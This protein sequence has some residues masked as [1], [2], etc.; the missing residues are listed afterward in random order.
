VLL[1]VRFT[2]NGVCSKTHN[3]I[4]VARTNEDLSPY[5][6]N[7]CEFLRTNYRMPTRWLTGPLQQSLSPPWLKP[8]VTPLIVGGR[9]FSTLSGEALPHVGALLT[10]GD[11]SVVHLYENTKTTTRGEKLIYKTFTF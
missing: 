5:I 9:H 6:G 10:Y 2:T 7:V 1:N 4:Y 3:H 11:N 8:L